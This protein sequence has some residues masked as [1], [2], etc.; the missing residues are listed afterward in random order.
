M[1]ST[2]KALQSVDWDFSSAPEAA[3]IH[4]I[5]PYTAKFI[6]QIPGRLIELF[7]PGDSSA[8]LDPFCGAGTTLVEGINR[9][10]DTW[11]IALQR[12]P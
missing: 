1:N 6:F 4:A 8:V 12:K 3:G 7:H 9:R 10:L 5:H 11:K 2:V